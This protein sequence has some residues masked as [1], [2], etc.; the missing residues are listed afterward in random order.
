MHP[1]VGVLILVTVLAAACGGSTPAAPASGV[2]SGELPAGP[3]L[4]GRGSAVTTRQQPPAAPELP[5]SAAPPPRPSTWKACQVRVLDAR[6]RPVP[7]AEASDLHGRA[8][9]DA[10]G[11]ATLQP[12]PAHWDRR[13][14]GRDWLKIRVRAEGFAEVWRMWN[15]DPATPLVFRLREEGLRIRGRCVD[16]SGD[17]VPDLRLAFGEIRVTTDADGRFETRTA[18]PRE[19]ALEIRSQDWIA[20]PQAV[21][22]PAEDLL[23]RVYRPAR[24]RARLRGEGWPYLPK[25][26]VQGGMRNGR[27][28][29]VYRFLCVPGAVRIAWRGRD[30]ARVVLAEGE[31]RND[32]EL[33]VPEDVEARASESWVEVDLSAVTGAPAGEAWGQW[34]ARGWVRLGELGPRAVTRL[35][36]PARGLERLRLRV[37]L[38]GVW[39]Q[40]AADET[41]VFLHSPLRTSVRV[42]L[43]YEAGGSIREG[44]LIA[45]AEGCADKVAEGYHL[46]GTAYPPPPVGLPPDPPPDRFQ[47]WGLGPGTYDLLW[48]PEGSGPRVRVLSGLVI[49]AGGGTR[50]LGVLPLPPPVELDVHVLDGDGVSVAGAVVKVSRRSSTAPRAARADADGVA[51]LRLSDAGPVI[52][53]ATDVAGRSGRLRVEDAKASPA[54]AIRL[55]R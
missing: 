46:I 14:W 17:G 26:E 11:A 43:L 42:G 54:V 53:E 3:R 27:S 2:A 30:L 16:A 41:R 49:G 5:G 25:F 47:V 15:Q 48:L 36:L 51:R 8:Y 18:P 21:V 33:W 32:L 34:A 4:S 22:P 40:P 7:G 12:R 19:L 6:G 29:G 23:V 44:R 52:L 20:P 37:H 31:V 55:G 28:G 24:I 1:A 9:T 45:R 35:P 38:V 50:D 39:E 10:D 13:Y